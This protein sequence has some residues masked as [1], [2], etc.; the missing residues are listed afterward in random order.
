[1]LFNNSRNSQQI[2]QDENDAVFFVKNS[3]FPHAK[4]SAFSAG[5]SVEKIR[6]FVFFGWFNMRI[7]N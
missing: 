5:K 7:P 3:R 2:I 1:M 6:F 4:N